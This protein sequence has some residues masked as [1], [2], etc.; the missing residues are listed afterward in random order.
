VGLGDDRRLAGSRAS[1]AP[2]R[3]L[4]AGLFLLPMSFGLAGCGSSTP[5][6]D[7]SGE[8]ILKAAAAALRGSSSFHFAATSP[9]FDLSVSTYKNGDSSGLITGGFKGSIQ[10]FAT[11]STLYFDTTTAVW[12]QLGVNRVA[13]APLANKWAVVP[14]AARAAFKG[15]NYQTLASQMTPADVTYT[16]HGTTTIG[17]EKVLVVSWKAGPKSGTWYVAATGTPYPVRFVE[18]GSQAQTVDLTG[19]NAQPSASPPSNTVALPGG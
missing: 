10:F 17:G 4:V 16:K 11:P 13:A 3:A 15:L 18:S 14:S 7:Q 12:Q 8:Q 9:V 5:L 6:A 1:R 19:W 2:R